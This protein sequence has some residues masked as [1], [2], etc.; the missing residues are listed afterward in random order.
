MDLLP[1]FAG[2]ASISFFSIGKPFFHYILAPVK[3]QALIPLKESRKIHHGLPFD[4]S[5]PFRNHYL[6][7]FGTYT[8][9]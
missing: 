6:P 2:N 5:P 9:K 1:V 8:K 3:R 7:P 4:G